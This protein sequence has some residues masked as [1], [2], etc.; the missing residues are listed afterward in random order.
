MASRILFLFSDQG[1]G[2]RA[3]ATAVQRAMENEYPG[4]FDIQLLDPFVE[5]SKPFLG[6]LVYRYNWLIKHMPRTYGMI[7]HGTD[8]RAMTRAAIRVL[9]NQFRPGIRRNLS[10]QEPAGVVSFHP[11]TNHLVA[12]AIEKVGL[13]VP[14]ITVI[15]DMSEFHRFWM[16]KKADVVVVPSPEA[17]RYCVRKGL[18]ARRV[19]VAGLPV[20]PRFTG[21]LHGRAKRDLRTRLGFEDRPTLLLVAGGE[22]AGRLAAQAKGL[23]AA[24]LGLQLIVICGRNDRLRAKVAARRYQGPVHVFGFVD[25]MPEL[26]QASDAIV[27]KAG[28]GTIAEALISGLPIFLTHFVPGQEEG[29]VHFVLEQ[30]VGYYTRSVRKLVAQVRHS[31]VEDRDEFERMQGH[32]EKVGRPGAAVEIADLVAAAVEPPDAID[33]EVL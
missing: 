13:D 32:A 22:G 14:F 12:E 26:M 10:D 7:F 23:D 33:E 9:G 27:T 31:W 28:P 4:R 5:G 16:S 19:H 24:G 15:T 1:A 2:H 11:L 21:P 17:R 6:W 8:N 20:D 3:S 25:N 30:G 18:D 29:N